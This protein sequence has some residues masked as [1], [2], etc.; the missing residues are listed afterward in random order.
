ML[1]D[2]ADNLSSYQ[3]SLRHGE[4]LLEV[5]KATGGSHVNAYVGHTRIA[6][7]THLQPKQI[8]QWFHW[9][10]TGDLPDEE[11]VVQ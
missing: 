2:W 1:N 8:R 7:K 4:R 11:R 10:S 5:Y 3:F 9:L 6:S